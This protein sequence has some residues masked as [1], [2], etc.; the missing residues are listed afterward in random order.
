MS[1]FILEVENLTKH[2]PV[3]RGFFSGP[4]TYA[5]AVDGLSFFIKKGETLGLV[6]ESGC[7]KSTVARLLTR[8]EEPTDGCIKL[9]GQDKRHLSQ[10][11]LV[12]YRQKIQMVFQDSVSSLHPRMSAGDLVAEPFHIHKLVPRNKINGRVKDL[13][14]SVGL[15]KEM[16]KRFPHELSGGQCQR[17]SVARALAVNPLLLV[18]DEAVSALDVSIQAQ[19]INLFRDLQ[20]RLNLSYLFISHDMAVVGLI[21]HR[22]AVM[23]LGQILEIGAKGDV[24]KEPLHP[25]TRAL[26][27]ASPIPNSKRRNRRHNLIQGELPSPINP[28]TGCRFHPRCPLAETRCSSEIPK[29]LDR[30]SEHFVACHL[31]DKL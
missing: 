8:L 23:Y 6:G 20:D 2:F 25:Y 17:L 24:I 22:I 26:L 14:E 3:N 27:D 28:P 18:A 30:G 11:E 15:N 19:V 5:R 29:L 31:A 10:S 1:K 9:D 7:G 16:L 12:L 4:T 13:F 21:S